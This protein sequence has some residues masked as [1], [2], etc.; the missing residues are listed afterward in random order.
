MAM[1][2]IKTWSPD[3]FGTRARVSR[4]GGCAQG[5]TNIC[6]LPAEFTI[7]YPDGTPIATCASHLTTYIKT[8][9]KDGR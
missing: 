7:V 1:F 2:E 5:G 8:Q 9:L 4:E 6:E 3:H